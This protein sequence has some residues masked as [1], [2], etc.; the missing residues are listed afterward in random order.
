M[1]DAT[2]QDAEVQEVEEQEQIDRTVQRP[3]EQM[4]EEIVSTRE[5]DVLEDIVGEEAMEEIM[6]EPMWN[7]IHIVIK[8]RPVCV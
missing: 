8:Y 1:A 3:R 2:P 4:M 5:L 7:P 6:A